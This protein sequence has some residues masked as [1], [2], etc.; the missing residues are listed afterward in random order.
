MTTRLG[1]GQQGFNSS[2]V[3]EI[4]LCFKTSRPIQGPQPPTQWVMGD[5]SPGIKQQGHVAQHLPLSSV[6]V[7]KGGAV[8]LPPYIPSWHAYGPLYF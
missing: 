3:Q 1:A 2:Q 6:G 4:F 5:Y 8:Y 7:K